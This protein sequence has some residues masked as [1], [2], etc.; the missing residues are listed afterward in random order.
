MAQL[1]YPYTAEI[2]VKPSVVNM[3][4]TV[5]KRDK[6]ISTAI[7]SHKDL[8]NQLKDHC[9]DKRSYRKDS[10]KQSNLS[11]RKNTKRETYYI[12]RDNPDVVISIEK[13][14]KLSQE[15]R[16]DYI[17]QNRE[18]L[19]DYS[20][21]SYIDISLNNDD[22]VIEDFTS[23]MNLCTHY[24][25]ICRYEHTILPEERKAPAEKKSSGRDGFSDRSSG[26]GLHHYLHGMKRFVKCFF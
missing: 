15:K 4:F 20:V 25:I 16:L 9:L 3:S 2:S 24:E 7:N 18:L 10:Y 1:I 14:E 11:F 8:V 5:T 19:V 12:R 23:I 21:T 17:P 6:D 26:T 13:Y 22:T